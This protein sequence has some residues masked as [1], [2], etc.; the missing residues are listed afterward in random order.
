MTALTNW[1]TKFCSAARQLITFYHRLTMSCPRILQYTTRNHWPRRSK[2]PVL[3]WANAPAA[4]YPP[5]TAQTRHR[6][7]CS[8]CRVVTIYH[9]ISI[10]FSAHQSLFGLVQPL[11]KTGRDPRVLIIHSASR[12]EE[13]L[14]QGK[15]ISS[16]SKQSFM[17]G[18]NTRP[19]NTK[20]QKLV[21]T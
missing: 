21:R 15:W 19:E 7:L 3:S 6:D 5:L 4:A 16:F 12:T 2:N 17:V 10:P 9:W 11:T 1:S 14:E 20:N 18:Q 13:E 8:L